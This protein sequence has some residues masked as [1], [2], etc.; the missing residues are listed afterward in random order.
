MVSFFV[1]DPL[2]YVCM[3]RCGRPAAFMWLSKPHMIEYPV[4]CHPTVVSGSNLL[5]SRGILVSARTTV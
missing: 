2:A 4:L 1:L 5:K 3:V